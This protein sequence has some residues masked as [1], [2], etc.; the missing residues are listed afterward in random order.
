MMSTR[1]LVL[2]FLGLFLIIFPA[3]LVLVNSY[4]QA[5]ADAINI[6]LVVVL[7]LLTAWYTY[8]AQETIKEVRK[9]RSLNIRPALIPS[10]IVIRD[11][12]AWGGDYSCTTIDLQNVGNGAAFAIHVYFLDP[13]SKKEFAKSQHH[14]DYLSSDGK[15]DDNHIHIKN[16]TLAEM[17]YKERDGEM[18]AHMTVRLVYDDMFGKE[19]SSERTF[20]VKKGERV[21]K[22]TMGSFR[23]EHVA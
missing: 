8:Y 3:G 15:T 19:Y 6:Y 13:E 16:K 2:V 20:A 12:N 1:N 4:V 14:I 21:F 5:Y 11:S 7:V 23:L 9:D 18:S 22:T 10:N 17:K